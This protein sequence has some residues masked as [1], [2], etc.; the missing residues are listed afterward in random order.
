MGGASAQLWMLKNLQRVDWAQ[1]A[2][3]AHCVA[4]S[5]PPTV[6]ARMADAVNRCIQTNPHKPAPECRTECRKP[7]LNGLSPYSYRTKRRNHA[8]LFE[9]F[10]ASG[11]PMADTF[12][13]RPLLRHVTTRAARGLAC[14]FSIPFMVLH[15]PITGE[16]WP[17]N[18][19]PLTPNPKP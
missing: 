13:G 4:F 19:Q 15:V 5:P 2:S 16:D 10:Y 1:T 7:S 6:D 12:L 14:L 8:G 9:T 3:T 18:T 17:L 11:D